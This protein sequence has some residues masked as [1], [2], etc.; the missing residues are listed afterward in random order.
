MSL[1]ML[2]MLEPVYGSVVFAYLN[3]DLVFT[4]ML[5]CSGLYYGMMTVGGQPQAGSQ[6]SVGYEELYII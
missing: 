3:V 4:T 6:Q 2:G 5:I 1:Y